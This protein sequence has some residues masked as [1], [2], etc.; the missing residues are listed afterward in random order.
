MKKYQTQSLYEASFLLSKD[1]RIVSKDATGQKT[2]L[3]FEDSPELQQAVMAF[4]NGA[5]T[6]SAKGL[7]DSYRSLKDMIFQR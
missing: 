5:G 3:V 7:F 2:S 1:F 6:T 4:Y